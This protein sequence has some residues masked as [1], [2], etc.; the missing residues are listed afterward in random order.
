MPFRACRTVFFSG[1]VD[2]RERLLLFPER[3]LQRRVHLFGS[4]GLRDMSV[5][6]RRVGGQMVKKKFPKRTAAR[7][8]IIFWFV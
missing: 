7:I 1:E 8:Q 3:R 5:H 4:S 2:A 6:A